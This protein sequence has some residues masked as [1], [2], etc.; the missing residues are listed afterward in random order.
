M[1]PPEYCPGIPVFDTETM[2]MAVWPNPQSRGDLGIRPWYISAG[3]RF[4]S[5]VYVLFMVRFHRFLVKTQPKPC[6][7]LLGGLETGGLNGFYGSVAAQ[8]FISRSPDGLACLQS[9]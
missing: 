2:G 4:L 9:R 8:Q 6:G 7:C 5:F 1:L 3:G